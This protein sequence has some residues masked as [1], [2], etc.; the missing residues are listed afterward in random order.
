MTKYQI[1]EYVIWRGTW[2][3]DE[4]KDAIIIDIEE[5]SDG[6]IYDLDNHHW[7]YEYQLSKYDKF[8]MVSV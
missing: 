8:I 6:T 7:A 4:P 1:G 2:G 3:K 5:S